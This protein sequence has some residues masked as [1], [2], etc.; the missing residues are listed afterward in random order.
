[1]TSAVSSTLISALEKAHWGVI[2]AYLSMVRGRSLSRD[3]DGISSTIEGGFEEGVSDLHC[4]SNFLAWTL[5]SREVVR[6]NKLLNVVLLL[7][8]H[9]SEVRCSLSLWMA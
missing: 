1:M 3:G 2:S 9:V 4:S 5:D 8:C 7:A 6:D